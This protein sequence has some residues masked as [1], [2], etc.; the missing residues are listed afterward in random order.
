MR[1]RIL[2]AGLVAGV[3]VVVAGIA[4]AAIP[5]SDGTIYACYNNRTRDLKVL[6]KEAGKSCGRRQ[7]EISWSQTGPEGP[8]G[9]PGPEGPSAPGVITETFTAGPFTGPPDGYGDLSEWDFNGAAVQQLFGE[10]VLIG[11]CGWRIVLDGQLVVEGTWSGST[12]REFDFDLPIIGDPESHELIPQVTTT[13][14]AECIARVTVYVTDLHP[15][16]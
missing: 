5:S 15:I 1:A 8:Q 13:G 11:S 16:S 9:S 3:A 7:T 10:W 14:V 12:P 4:F 2:A 6:D